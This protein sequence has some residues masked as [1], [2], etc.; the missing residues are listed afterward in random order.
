MERTMTRSVFRSVMVSVLAAGLMLGGRPAAAQQQSRAELIRNLERQVR[1]IEAQIQGAAAE[2]GGIIQTG[3]EKSGFTEH[4]SY[5]D[6]MTFLQ[7]IQANSTEMKLGSYGKTFEGRELPYAIFSRPSITQPWEAMV[8][9]KPIVVLAANVHGGERTLRESVLIMIREL[10]TPGTELNAYLDDLVILTVP[11]I[12]PD[13][14][15]RRTRGNSWGI[16]MNRD[17]MKLEQAA[18]RNLVQNIHN[19]WHPHL[20]ID[21]HN[22]GSYPYNLCYQANSNASPDQRL[23]LICDQEIFPL[24][25]RRMEEK[26]YK[27]FYY[28]GGNRESWR[29]GG[30]DPRISRNYG[31]FINSIGIL[32]ESPG[33]QELRVG[34][35]SG[36]VAYTAVLEYV[37]ANADKVMSYVNRARRETIEMGDNPTGEVMVNMEYG[38]EDYTVTYE[39]S[40]GQGEE[41]R[42]IT[43]TDGKLMKKPVVTKTRTRA[44]AYLLPREA[45]DAVAMLRRHGITIEVLQAA[46]ELDIEAYTLADA[47]YQREY[48][49]AAAVNVTVGEVVKRTQTFPAGTYVIPTGQMMGRVVTHLLEPETADNVV[50]WNAMDAWLPKTRMGQTQDP[51]AQNPPAGRQGRGRGAQRGQRGGGQQGAGRGAAGRGRGAQQGQ[52]GAGRGRGQAAG[53]GA[54]GRGRGRGRGQQGPPVIPIYKVMKPVPMPTK[55]LGNG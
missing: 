2:A 54:R 3:C 1:E 8:S 50:H 6:M 43:V 33:R 21:G 41:R 20:I 44:Y 13:G 26:G 46:T 30:Y 5:P 55:I 34:A 45:V 40:E 38:P 39:I 29:G 15:S 47:Q 32:F 49:H 52:R 42:L 17:Y 53:R 16:D 14:F 19:T 27:S 24:I 48:N 11:S 10:A 23:T 18:L 31:A 22:G 25:N 28:S 4:T 35:M 36:K 51:Q 9:G 37:R 12:N 7:E